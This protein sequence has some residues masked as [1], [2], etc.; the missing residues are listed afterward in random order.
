MQQLG[1]SFGEINILPAT[2]SEPHPPL[3]EEVDDLY[4]YPHEIMAQPV[5]TVSLMTGFNINVRVYASYAPLS[6]MEMAFGVNELFDWDRQQKLIDQCLQNCKQV[7]DN[8]PEVLKV[9]PKD[10]QNGRFGQRKQPYYPPMPEY[11][12]VRDPSLA[13]FNKGDAD[14]ARREAQ[15]EIQKANIYASHLSIRSYLVE[16]YFALLDMH[17]KH[18]GQALQDP[19]GGALLSGIDRFISPAAP[20]HEA[21]EKSMAEEREQVVK[22]VLVVLGNIDMVNMEPNGDSF[23]WVPPS[24]FPC[25]GYAVLEPFEMGRIDPAHTQIPPQFQP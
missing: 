7:M 9:L 13:A 4:I 3:P 2:P 18:K 14:E 17:N 21:L 12:S 16:K 8:I 6:T 15:F 1:A 22:D 11:I 23:V 5:G 25:P 10:T 20:E 19:V 24:F